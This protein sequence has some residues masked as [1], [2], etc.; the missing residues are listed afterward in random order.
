MNLKFFAL[1]ACA[2]YGIWYATVGG[3][4]LDEEHVAALYRDY[5]S[6]YQRED[7]KA[8]CDLFS[9]KVHGRFDNKNRSPLVQPVV[10][11]ASACA[12]VAEFHG[13]KRQLEAAAGHALHTNINVSIQSVSIAPDK[14]TATAEVLF[15]KR[16]GTE[17]ATLFD[18]RSTQTDVIERDFGK[19]SFVQSDGSVRF[20]KSRP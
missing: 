14:K 7:E 13:L 20:F 2:G 11:K 19:A 8:V 1:A 9:D 18:M 6:A 15:E 3:R 16:I 4:Q 10:S 5:G 17:N 12:S